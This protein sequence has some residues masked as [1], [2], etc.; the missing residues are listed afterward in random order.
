MFYSPL[1][2]SAW[3]SA[4]AHGGLPGN[5]GWTDRCMVAELDALKSV[6]ALLISGLGAFVTLEPSFSFVGKNV[7]ERYEGCGSSVGGGLLS[8]I[9]DKK[10][11][12]GY[13]GLSLNGVGN[14]HNLD[15]S[16]LLGQRATVTPMM[17]HGLR[18]SLELSRI[19]LRESAQFSPLTPQTVTWLRSWVW[20]SPCS[21]VDVAG[22]SSLAT[23]L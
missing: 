2:P 4:L 17:F 11:L 23:G 1:V 19:P 12:L 21:P 10:W 13:I 18:S 20:V 14:C 15:F 8:R 9:R 7:L 5:T 6:L 3:T 16:D 22:V